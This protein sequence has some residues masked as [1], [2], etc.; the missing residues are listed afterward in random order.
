MRSVLLRERKNDVKVCDTKEI[1]EAGIKAHGGSA[2][3]PNLTVSLVKAIVGSGILALPA[4]VA[5]LGNDPSAVVIP[6]IALIVF[7]GSMNAFFFALIGRVCYM[8]GA[9][10]Y[11]EA[12]EMTV[13]DRGSDLIAGSVAA[14]TALSCLAFSIVLADSFRALFIA[15][16]FLEVTRTGALLAVTLAALLPLCLLKDLKSLAPF[17]ALGLSGIGFTISTMALRCFDGTYD[18]ETGGMFLS[19]TAERFQPSFGNEGPFPQGGLVLACLL[20][21]AN[22]AH[23]NA[24][25]FYFELKDNTPRRF[26]TV[27]ASAYAIAAA[28][29]TAVALLGFLTFGSNST[30]L[31]L[32][33]YASTDPLATL[34]RAAVALSLVFTYPI[35]F[36]GFRD[37]VL[38][39]LWP[40]SLPADE[41]GG[42]VGGSDRGVNVD[43]L[44]VALLG[45][46]TVLAVNVQ[47]LA[48]VLS[49]GG[50]TFSTA[51]A[52]VFPALMYSAAVEQMGEEASESD[53]LAAKV[54][55]GLM[56]SGIFVG[57]AG[58]MFSLR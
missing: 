46:V 44:S 49:V 6:S 56:W 58:V 43:A 42:N 18:P 32:N 28:A 7:A 29:F 36:L 19:E 39:L 8:T 30:G 51:V 57:I 5:S 53:V 38:S 14:K 35:A 3:V 11:R 40:Q 21:T 54:G 33:N 41:N 22:V 16:G 17:S 10:S 55:L 2:T 13:G 50:G 9:T 31:I 52:T 47:D 27:V 24:P 37:G 4:G 45:G 26:G 1:A 48:I 25:R 20:A 15:A 34:S 12:W 23:Y